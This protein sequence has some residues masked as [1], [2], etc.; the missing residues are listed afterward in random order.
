[1]MEVRLPPAMATNG[2]WLAMQAQHSIVR[3]MIT[4]MDTW[5]PRYGTTPGYGQ[6]MQNGFQDVFTTT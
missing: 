1:M 2:T 5:H 3:A 4:R 6:T